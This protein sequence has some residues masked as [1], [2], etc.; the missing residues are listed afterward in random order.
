MTRPT[1][2]QLGEIPSIR[3]ILNNSEFTDAKLTHFYV[4]KYVSYWPVNPYLGNYSLTKQLYLVSIHRNGNR[5]KFLSAS[6]KN[7]SGSLPVLGICCL[8]S[9]PN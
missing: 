2:K 5:Y 1:F 4:L 3:L 8:R 9:E 6:L 7:F